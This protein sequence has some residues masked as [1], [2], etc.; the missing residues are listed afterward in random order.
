MRLYIDKG[1]L[2]IPMGQ[3]YVRDVPVG[4]G[5]VTSGDLERLSGYLRDRRVEVC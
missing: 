2:L 5:N 4:T 1:D 3:E